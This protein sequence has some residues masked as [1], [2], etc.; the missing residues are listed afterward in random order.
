M[1]NGNKST[2]LNIVHS[3]NSVKNME[4]KGRKHVAGWKCLF[5]GGEPTGGS[6]LYLSIFCLLF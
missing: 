4:Q 5:L 2:K 6:D 1:L 3:Y